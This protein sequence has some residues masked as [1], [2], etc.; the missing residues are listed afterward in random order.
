MKRTRVT[1]EAI[2][3]AIRKARGVRSEAAKLLAISC[4]TVYARLA[5]MPAER[6]PPAAG[7]PGRPKPTIEA[8]MV[9]H[10]NDRTDV[11][12]RNHIVEHYLA[13]AYRT[14]EN[15][16]KRLPAN[17]D[18]HEVRSAAHKALLEAVERFDPL[19]GVR[20]EIYAER[21][22]RGEI[23]DVARRADRCSRHKRT[24]V[25]CYEETACQ[26]AHKLGRPP[27]DEEVI[28]ETTWTVG[29]VVASQNTIQ[30][31]DQV[32]DLVLASIPQSRTDRRRRIALLDRAT[33]HLDV[34]QKTVAYLLYGCGYTMR[35]VG[36]LLHFTESWISQIAAGIR[37]FCRETAKHAVETDSL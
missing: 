20:F 30:Y 34:E 23:R 17:I 27:T 4:G 22:L 28:D 13:W 37:E 2:L 24:L 21:R 19:R 16:A 3:D 15:A 6:R 25:R 5:K 32:S 31:G 18:R 10:A 12:L 36:H 9:R 26:L 7:K 1:D 11:Q 8:L 35:E 29:D 14:V 33:N